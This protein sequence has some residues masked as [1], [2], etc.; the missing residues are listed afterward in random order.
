MSSYCVCRRFQPGEGP[1]RGLLHD[2]TTS[3]INRLQHY[4]KFTGQVPN[5][6]CLTWYLLH[7]GGERHG[8]G[9][10]GHGHAGHLHHHGVLSSSRVVQF[11]NTERWHTHYWEKAPSSAFSVLKVSVYTWYWP[12]PPCLPSRCL[13]MWGCR[14]LRSPWPGSRGTWPRGSSPQPQTLWEKHYTAAHKA[15]IAFTL[16]QIM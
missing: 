4:S 16:L 5:I 9:G 13:C 8:D 14:P 1:S 11:R 2:C 3:P 10:D 6:S 15:T 7:D 12:A